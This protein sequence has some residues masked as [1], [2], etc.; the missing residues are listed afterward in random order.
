[1]INIID[2]DHWYELR[3]KF[4]SDYGRTSKD[5]MSDEM[6]EYII[7]DPSE[8]EME[9]GEMTTFDKGKKVYLPDELQTVNKNR[10]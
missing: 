8:G 5:I 7:T 3:D 4:C 6:G 10:Q 9:D 2:T 1:M